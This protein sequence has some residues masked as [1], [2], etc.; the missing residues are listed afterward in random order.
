MLE[1]DHHKWNAM[2]GDQILKSSV[3]VWEVLANEWCR[4]CL[5]PANRKALADAITGAADAE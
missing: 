2:V 5:A 3:S 1:P 4:S